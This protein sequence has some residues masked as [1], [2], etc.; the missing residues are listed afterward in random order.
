M[1]VMHRTLLAVCATVVMVAG[2]GAVTKGAGMVVPEADLVHH[3][4]AALSQGRLTL[5][6]ESENHG[7]AA[8]ENATLRLAFSTPLA[9]D[10]ELPPSCLWS[11]DSVVLCATGPLGAGAAGR[12]TVLELRAEEAPDEVVLTVG[13]HWN[14]GAADGRPANNEHEVLVPGTGEPSVF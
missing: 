11:G 10:R 14:G 12:R 2:T 7:P 9:G 3:G 8:L 1:A 4:R 13:T 6:V 5:S